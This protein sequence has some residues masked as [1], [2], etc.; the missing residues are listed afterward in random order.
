MIATNERSHHGYV[1][2]IVLMMLMIFSLLIT[3]VLV[4]SDAQ[5]R[6]VERQVAEYRM[7][8]DMFGA[9]AL[10]LQWVQRASI[11][12]IREL[13]DTDARAFGFVLEPSGKR[14]SVRIYDGQSTALASAAN[15]TE[16]FRDIYWDML[17]AIPLNRPDLF[18]A[19][20]PEQISMNTAPREI[21]EALFGDP[22][23]TAARRLIRR[24]ARARIDMADLV[25]VLND[26][27]AT[28]EENRA[29]THILVPAPTL[30]RLR[31]EVEDP[32]LPREYEMLVEYSETRPTMHAWRE[33]FASES[34]NDTDDTRRSRRR[35]R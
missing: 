12:D 27:G 10:V 29:I 9:Q 16:E 4:R 19:S 15:V 7:H 3:G 20:G 30:L 11:S 28:P 35:G 17:D 1:L 8:H 23:A 5:M 14:I 18:R 13:T 22:L 31:V 2:V 26:G 33:V 6:L 25:D 24:R 34:Q 21:I 32:V